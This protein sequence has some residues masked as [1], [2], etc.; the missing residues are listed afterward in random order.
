MGLDVLYITRVTTGVGAGFP[1]PTAVVAQDDQVS[2]G[3]PVALRFVKVEAHG[4]AHRS[5]WKDIKA[6]LYASGATWAELVTRDRNGDTDT[7]WY[8]R[9]LKGVGVGQATSV[10]DLD[11]NIGLS[12][13]ARSGVDVN[14]AIGV[15]GHASADDLRVD[16]RKD[17]VS[18]R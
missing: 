2:Q 15:N 9:Y 18:A 13:P 3:L 14:V 10:L 5:G 17:Q 8:N 12:G 11:L 1:Y 7:G 6:A 16:E 4:G